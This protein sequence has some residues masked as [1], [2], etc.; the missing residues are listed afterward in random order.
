MQLREL[1]PPE[2]IVVPLKATT[3]LGALNALVARLVQRGAVRSPAHLASLFETPELRGAVAV[4]GAVALPHFRTE[5]VDRLVLA[6][7]IAPEP[8]DPEGTGLDVEPRLVVLVLAPVETATL[9]L[10]TISTLARSLRRPELLQRV[11]ASRSADEVLALADEADLRIQPSLSV[12]DVMSPAAARIRPDA[13]LR[14]AVEL[15]MRQHVALI[16]VVGEKE[17]VL[18]TVGERDIMRG[19]L[20]QMPRAGE[21]SEPSKSPAL[22]DLR[23]RDV[24]MRS[25][26][27]VSEDMGLEEAAGIL[28]NKDVALIPVVSEGRL[29]GILSRGD[30]IRKLFGR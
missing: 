11:L 7:G 12:R 1:L 22:Q 29:T 5:A 9:Y 27:C 18:G 17:E 19:L 13:P 14:E 24:M 26:L 16:P 10:Q 21:E 2:H 8:L 30:V 3:V 4:G 6:L 20:P 25:V 23:V 28:I 15:I